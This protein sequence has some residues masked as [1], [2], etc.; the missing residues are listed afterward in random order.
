MEQHGFGASLS[1]LSLVADET[2]RS[3][4]AENPNGQAGGGGRE[5]SLLGPGRKGRPC[6][7]I[8]RGCTAEL[9]RIEGPG[10]IRHIW[11]TV[12][13]KPDDEE[14][15][16]RN[17]VLRMHWD[18]EE[19]PSV[20]V[21]LG[22]FFCNG[23]GAAC[24]VDSLPI[25]VNPTGGMNGYFP[26]PFRRNARITLENQH[27][28]D[29]GALFY[30]IDYAL[31]PSL[32]EN[33]AT[34]HAQW[35]RQDP[36]RIG[37]DFVLLDH[38]EGMGHYVGTYLAYAALEGCWWGEGEIKF[39]LDGDRDLPTICGTGT[40]DYFGGAWCFLEENGGQADE[41]TYSTAFLGHPYYRRLGPPI[42]GKGPLPGA[43]LH[44]LYRWHIPDPIRFKKELRVTLQQIGH[45][46]EQLFERADDVSSV[47]YWYQTEPHVRFPALLDAKARKPRR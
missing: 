13:D 16:L 45:D 23:F 8:L 29:V 41:A 46:T 38:A 33:A 9:A 37:E 24:R 27:P 40:E 12:P 5:S 19:D 47:A 34:F 32:P 22:D 25:S 1:A 44:G 42:P 17:L 4:S 21:P 3:I 31:L 30:Q 18:D 11:I 36:T 20:E 35:H 6:I 15:I 43:A 28:A 7:D 2:S 26:M 14:R 39:Y 10:E